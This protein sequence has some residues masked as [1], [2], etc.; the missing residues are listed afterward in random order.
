MLGATDA[1]LGAHFG[2]AERTIHRWKQDHPGFL[3]ALTEG[4]ALADARVAH[5]LYHRAIGYSHRAVKIFQSSGR[6][7]EHE[8][9]EYFPPDPVSCI[10]W[11]KNRRPDLW[12]DKPIPEGPE[13]DEMMKELAAAIK[14]SPHE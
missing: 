1:E 5:A 10:F 9:T 14:D 13:A 6:S 2:V 11:L 3:K 12:R 4:K 8:Y 7:F